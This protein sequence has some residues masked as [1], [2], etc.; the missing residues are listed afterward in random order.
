MLYYFLPSPKPVMSST[1]GIIWVT[2]AV[3]N[4][5][6]L[7]QLTVIIDNLFKVSVASDIFAGLTVQALVSEDAPTGK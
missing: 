5:T 7:D 3:M 4:T 2:Q 1:T 6:W